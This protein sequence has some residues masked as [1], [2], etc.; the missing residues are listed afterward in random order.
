MSRPKH[1]YWS[2][3]KSILREYPK[4]KKLIETPLEP[5]ITAPINPSDGGRG[6]MISNPTEACVIHDIP[7]NLQRK[8]DAI[9]RAIERT[10]Y[11]HPDD[12]IE[13]LLVIDLVYWRQTHTIEGASLR[14]PCHRNT[15][16]AWQAE[17]IKIVAEE[18]DL[19]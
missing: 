6:S 12:Y 10:V 19:V 1:P 16:C 8:Y 7:R 3:V 5:R 18:L 11:E 4:L 15:A 17:F 9:E 14:V 2:Y 13:R